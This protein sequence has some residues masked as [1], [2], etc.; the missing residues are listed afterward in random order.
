MGLLDENDKLRTVCLTGSL[1]C[2]DGTAESQ[3]KSIIGA[4][5][6]SGKMLDELTDFLSEM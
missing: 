4:F 3:S 6:E 2:E 5:A 1:I